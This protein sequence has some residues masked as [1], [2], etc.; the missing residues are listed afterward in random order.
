M[1]N[2]AR[3]GEKR[4]V[5]DMVVEVNVI[6]HQSVVMVCPRRANQTIK[7]DFPV[8]V[9][10]A[11]QYGDNLNA[12]AV[13]LNT[14]GMVSV[15]RTHEIMSNMFDIPISSN[16]VSR[17]AAAVTDTVNNIRDRVIGSETVHFDETGTRV[18]GK[19]MWFHN[20]ST[21]QL[22]HLTVNP[23]RGKEGMDDNGVLPKFKGNAVHDCFASYWKYIVTHVLCCAH[24]LRELTGVVEN[25]PEQAWAQGMIDLLLR[26]KKARDDAVEQG[27]ESLSE[28]MLLEFSNEYDSLVERGRLDNPIP[29]K[30]QGKRGR[31]AKGKVRA[32]VERLAEQKESF[33]RFAHDFKA[34]FDN[35]QA[36]R[37]IRMVKTKTKVSGCFRSKTGADDFA[38]LMSYIGTA[39]KLGFNS[40]YAIKNAVQGESDFIFD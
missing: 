11:V 2:H 28:H 14:I 10:A 7:G 36:E 6:E 34:P 26:M 31:Q 20:S 21:D 4:H 22:T 9:S 12:F 33:C 18:E 35:N 15:K 1:K 17:C 38:K 13:A 39:K 3:V 27:V 24:L 16:M 40:F 8:N 30:E 5:I 32:L 37:D 25:R 29:E 23:K 19:T